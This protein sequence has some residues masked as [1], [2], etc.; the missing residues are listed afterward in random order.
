MSL[1]NCSRNRCPGLAETPQTAGA[2]TPVVAL[3][4]VVFAYPGAARPALSVARFVIHPGE[5]VFLRG[6]SGTGKTTLLGIVAGIHTPQRGRVSV[7]GQDL[8]KMPHSA[9]DGFR[10]RHIGY[11]FQ[12]FNLIPYLNVWDNVLIQCDLLGRRTSER[13]GRA[14]ALLEHLG[15]A[16]ERWRAVTELSVGQQQRVA[17]AR[18]LVLQPELVIADEP[19]SALDTE[20]RAAFLEALF[21]LC[22]E[23]RSALLFVSH[24]PAL[25]EHFDTVIELS[26]INSAASVARPQSRPGVSGVPDP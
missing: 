23:N 11:I 26:A 14:E 25:H 6:P 8:T 9:R 17:A 5:K 4:D 19:T 15:L 12:M 10:G 24:D 2:S 22:S 21:D 7:L 1:I 20:L 18:A 13:L 3:Q 16:D